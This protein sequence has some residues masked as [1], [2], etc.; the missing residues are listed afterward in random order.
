[1]NEFSRKSRIEQNRW[2]KKSIS[3]KRE[4]SILKVA[5]TFNG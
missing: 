5:R 2:M 3:V 1:M 4:S